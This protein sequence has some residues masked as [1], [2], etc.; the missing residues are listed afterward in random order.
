MSADDGRLHITQSYC[1]LDVR[2][3]RQQDG[4]SEAGPAM[5]NRRTAA[6]LHAAW[7]IGAPTA[8]PAAPAIRGSCTRLRILKLHYAM[9][10]NG[11]MGGAPDCGSGALDRGEAPQNQQPGT[12]RAYESERHYM[13]TAAPVATHLFVYRQAHQMHGPSL[14]PH[15]FIQSHA[16]ADKIL[17]YMAFVLASILVD[18]PALSHN[19][20]VLASRYLVPS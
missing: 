2:G 14:L 10:G 5:C 20:V 11:A 3:K 17:K 4:A 1:G 8:A 18:I 13:Q 15:R 19:L 9:H 16:T 6:E 12:R 7:L